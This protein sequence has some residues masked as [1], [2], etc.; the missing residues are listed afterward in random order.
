MADHSVANILNAISP[1]RGIRIARSIPYGKGER[2]TLDVYCPKAAIAAPVI[3][4]FYG[5][6]W[7]SGDKSLYKFVG[8]ALA[9]RGFVVA[10]PDYRVY[11]EVRYQ[12]FLND[13][14]NALRWTRDNAGRFAGDPGKLFVMGHSAG[15]YIAAMLALDPRW[16]RTVNLT[17]SG[18]I[19]GL[20][21]LSGPY[22]FLPIKDPTLQIIFGSAH[23]ATTQPISHVSANAPP[24]LLLSGSHDR[25]VGV[26]NSIRLAA[27][28]RAAGNA[29]GVRIFRRVGHLG[30]VGAFAWP[31]RLLA[32]ALRDIVAFVAD[33]TNSKAVG[34]SFR[35]GDEITA[36]AIR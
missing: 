35:A 10:I 25:T 3:V 1:E 8:A 36:E 26:G 4:F 23:D 15:A 9:R 33:V 31:L 7:Q 20:I 16:L 27:R 30:V 5:G 19:R 32:P 17:P 12:G 28:L 22:D 18:V 21:G 2:Q 14:A 11:P 34:A 13:A 24:A 6:S 29:V